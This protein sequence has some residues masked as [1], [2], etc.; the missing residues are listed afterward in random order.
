MGVADNLPIPV[1]LRSLIP[2][3]DRLNPDL[4]RRLRFEV[5]RFFFEILGMIFAGLERV[6]DPQTAPVFIANIDGGGQILHHDELSSAH[7]TPVD[8]Q[9]KGLRISAGF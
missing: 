9:Q 8:L 6:T 7:I 5:R 3:N 4:T 2:L 1:R